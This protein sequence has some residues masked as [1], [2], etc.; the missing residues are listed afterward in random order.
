[1]NCQGVFQTGAL[2]VVLIQP[3]NSSMG[4]RYTALAC[5]RFLLMKPEPKHLAQG[6]QSRSSQQGFGTGIQNLPQVQSSVQV[7][8]GYRPNEGTNT[9]MESG[10]SGSKHFT[11]HSENTISKMFVR[12]DLSEDES[13]LTA[14]L[15]CLLNL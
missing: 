15:S 11:S 6:Q 8:L 9:T 13:S 4:L 3:H 10:P 5:R 1:M 2:T 12:L 7:S 14:P